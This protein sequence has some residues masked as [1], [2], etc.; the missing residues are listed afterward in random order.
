MGFQVVVSAPQQLIFCFR[1]FAH[2]NINRWMKIGGQSFYYYINAFA[3]TCIVVVVSSSRTFFTHRGMENPV[4]KVHSALRSLLEFGRYLNHRPSSL[5][6][7]NWAS[8]NQERKKNIPHRNRHMV[9]VRAKD[10]RR[11]CIKMC[12]QRP[13]MKQMMKNACTQP[14]PSSGNRVPP[15]A[16]K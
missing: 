8:L 5:L 1:S 10:R 11:R 12:V 14:K 13:A 9:R 16:A 4:W 7:N 15:G 2:L 3:R 6:T